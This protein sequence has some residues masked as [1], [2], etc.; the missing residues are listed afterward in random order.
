MKLEITASGLTREVDQQVLDETKAAAKAAP[1]SAHIIT[2]ARDE[3]RRQ[4]AKAGVDD[5]V[6]VTAVIDI[7]AKVTKKEAAKKEDAK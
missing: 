7:E 1:E 5:E 6:E 4:Y 3:I 2:A